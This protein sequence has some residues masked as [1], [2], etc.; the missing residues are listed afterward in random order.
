MPDA[1]PALDTDYPL[2][3]EQVGHYREKGW[4][5]LRGVASATLKAAQA[6]LVDVDG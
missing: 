1:L 3:P 4:A 2:A 5:L 6:F